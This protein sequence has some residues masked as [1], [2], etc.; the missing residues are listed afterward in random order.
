MGFRVDTYARVWKVEN[1]GKYSVA[2]IS[3]SKKDS[4]TNTYTVDFQDGFVR[5]VGQAHQAF[6]GV[7]IDEKR[8]VS[9]KIK[10]CEVTNLYTSPDGKV[11]YTPHY[12]IF[13]VEMQD[14]NNN[15]N[16][17]NNNKAVANSTNNNGSD[18]YMSIPESDNEELPFN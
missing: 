11:S 2:R 16:N 3:I 6:Q 4:S 7:N 18:E 15:N 14:N 9:I 12:T 1:K 17:N 5:L 8:G 13:G 10:S